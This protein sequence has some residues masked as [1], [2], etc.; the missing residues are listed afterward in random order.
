MT[1]PALLNR[2]LTLDRVFAVAPEHFRERFQRPNARPPRSLDELA[3]RPPRLDPSLLPGSLRGWLE[4]EASRLGVPLAAV[5]GPALVAAGATIGTTAHIRVMQHNTGWTEPATLWGANVGTSGVRKTPTLTAALRPVREIDRSKQIAF[6]ADSHT[7]SAEAM[8]LERRIK[9]IERA[10]DKGKAGATEGADLAKLLKERQEL[11]TERPRLEV[12]DTTM[13]RL[14]T[15]AH[16]NPRGLLMIRDELAGLLN[17]MRRD[18]HEGDRPFYLEAYNPNASH[19]FDRMSR[20]TTF[21][22]PLAVSIF[23]L[24]QPSVLQ[25]HIANLDRTAG[26]DGFFARFQLVTLIDPADVGDAQDR[27][28]DTA[29]EARALATFRALD[30][31]ALAAIDGQ[32]RGYHR[33]VQFDA[34]A[35]EH[36]DRWRKK[37][38][39]RARDLGESA[40]AAF[41][42]KS[43]ATGAR[44]ALV[45]H[46]LDRAAGSTA[47]AV[48]LDQARQATGLMDHFAAHAEHLYGKQLHPH[49]ILARS[50]ADKIRDGRVPDGATVTDV[51][52]LFAARARGSMDDVREALQLLARLD[53]LTVE[54]RRNPRTKPTHVVRLNPTFLVGH[55]SQAPLK[56]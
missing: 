52:N 11:S 46:M 32:A 55:W 49:A 20:D 26:G 42:S 36:F 5:A 10:A 50:I 16:A 37:L 41:L 27:V 24:I 17:T 56:S 35:Q 18:G 23:G 13:E 31:Q 33:Q 21:V 51:G 19:T 9:N 3:P 40:L 34:A 38:E 2:P 12:N 25:D 28:M 39:A 15:L 1:L 54:E 14:A 29:S 30:E 47:S 22:Y 44:L 53:W 43:P 45:I 48:T 4:D 7:R 6:N 8:L